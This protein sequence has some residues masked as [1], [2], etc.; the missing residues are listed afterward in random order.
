MSGTIS[1]ADQIGRLLALTIGLC[2][3]GVYAL[4]EHHSTAIGQHGRERARPHALLVVARLAQEAAGLELL[5]GRVPRHGAERG[6]VGELPGGPQEAGG[7]RAAVRVGAAAQGGGHAGA[8]HQRQVQRHGR[9]ALRDHA[10]RARQAAPAAGQQVRLDRHGEQSRAR[11][12]VV[13]CRKLSEDNESVEVVK[14]LESVELIDVPTT[15]DRRA[16]SFVAY[17]YR[18]PVASGAASALNTTRRV[19]VPKASCVDM[20]CHLPV[21]IEINNPSSAV[22]DIRSELAPPKTEE[23]LK[24]REFAR[25]AAPGGRGRGRGRGRGPPGAQ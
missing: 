1:L 3:S 4:L 13:W 12:S 6:D 16:P 19:F 23:E 14:S 5:L 18:G 25:P 8:R 20:S 10:E 22:D 21:Q 15:L 7:G 11:S 17:R 24:P 9:R 2:D